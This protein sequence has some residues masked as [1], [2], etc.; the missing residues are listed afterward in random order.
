MKEREKAE[1]WCLGYKVPVE[2]ITERPKTTWEYSYLH[3]QLEKT[4]WEDNKGNLIMEKVSEEGTVS[5]LDPRKKKGP[6]QQPKGLFLDG[7]VVNIFPL[8]HI[9]RND[10]IIREL[11]PDRSSGFIYKHAT[12]KT[13][14]GK[15]VTKYIKMSFGPGL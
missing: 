10:L 6:Y 9:G 12:V 2:I 4:E 15:D 5:A 3:G 7:P 11:P 13:L 8:P 1:R 14:D